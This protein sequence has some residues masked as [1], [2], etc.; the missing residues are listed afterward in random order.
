MGQPARE[1]ALEGRDVP[2]RGGELFL[3]RHTLCL[4]HLDHIF[5]RAAAAE[6][7]SSATQQSEVEDDERWVRKGTKEAPQIGNSDPPRVWIRK[8][9]RQPREIKCAQTLKAG[10]SASG[11]HRRYWV[12]EAVQEDH[13]GP[14]RRAG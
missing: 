11:E 2:A 8:E 4:R 12:Q 5:T 14:H 13:L 10:H 6:E 3:V 9:P 1:F 7:V